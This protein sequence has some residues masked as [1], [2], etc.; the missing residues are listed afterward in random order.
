MAAAVVREDTL[1]ICMFPP[2]GPIWTVLF[3]ALKL[4]S[5][6]SIGWGIPTTRSE[7]R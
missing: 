1:I 2:M 3:V 4:G 5:G 6:Q 7:V